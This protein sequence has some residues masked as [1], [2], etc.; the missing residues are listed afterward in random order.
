MSYKDDR[1]ISSQNA[2]DALIEIL[3]RTAK[4][5]KLSWQL[6]YDPGQQ[7]YAINIHPVQ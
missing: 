7:L 2:R 1:G 6:L 4:G 5:K 3:T